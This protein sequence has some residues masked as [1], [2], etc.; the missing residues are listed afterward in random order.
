M[1][2][3]MQSS[4]MTVFPKLI[5]GLEVSDIPPTLC[6]VVLIAR[7]LYMEKTLPVFL[8]Y[9][10]NSTTLHYTSDTTCVC[11]FHTSSNLLTPARCPTI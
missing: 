2:R 8:L 9:S 10:H 11:V 7:A 3:I 1:A 5:T 4:S 6:N